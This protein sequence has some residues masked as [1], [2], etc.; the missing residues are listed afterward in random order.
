[1]A[2]EDLPNDAPTATEAPNAADTK[3][4]SPKVPRKGSTRNAKPV[5]APAGGLY[6]VTLLGNVLHP[7]TKRM[8]HGGASIEVTRD[9][10]IALLK[11]GKI[12]R[13]AFL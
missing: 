11:A 3:K 2:N 7:Q 6:E 9:E 12:L 4:R 8:C 5:A 13:P 1:M 10:A